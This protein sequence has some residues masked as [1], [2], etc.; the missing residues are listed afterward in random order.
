MVTLKPLPK[1]PV[2]V[3][4]VTLS[5][6][7]SSAADTIVTLRFAPR[8]M[9]PSATTCDPVMVTSRPAAIVTASPESV[10]PVVRVP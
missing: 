1:T 2:V 8:V 5:E 3:F 4:S 10:L 6:L 9:S 7:L